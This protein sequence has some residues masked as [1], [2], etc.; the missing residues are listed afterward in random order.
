MKRLQ[1]NSIRLSCDF[2]FLLLE[3][4]IGSN[5]DNCVQRLVFGCV[6]FYNFGIDFVL[7]RCL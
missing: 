4:S 7:N 6:V 1:L 2:D 5:L 3:F